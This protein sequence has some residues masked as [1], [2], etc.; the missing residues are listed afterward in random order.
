MAVSVGWLVGW[1]VC[2]LGTH[3]FDDPYVAPIGLLGLVDLDV[4]GNEEKL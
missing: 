1:L 4:E 3:L 2:L